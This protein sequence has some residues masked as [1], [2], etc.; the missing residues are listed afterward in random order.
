M[1]NWL[2]SAAYRINALRN[3]NHVKEEYICDRNLHIILQNRY[4]LEHASLLFKEN[5]MPRRWLV[6]WLQCYEEI[7]TYLLFAFLGD[8]RSWAIWSANRIA[9]S[10]LWYGMWIN[11]RLLSGAPF[12]V[13]DGRFARGFVI[14]K[15]QKT[16]LR[17]LC[18]ALYNDA[19]LFLS[20]GETFALFDYLLNLRTT[21]TL[22]CFSFQ[23]FHWSYI[24]S[25]FGE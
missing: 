22:D 1:I 4:Q 10:E 2:A 16:D 5:F 3:V 9:A 14:S 19:Y 8:S 11:K 12:W 7:C 15:K 25:I 17:T 20:G 24:M 18:K 23:Y 21:Y 13:F 6:F